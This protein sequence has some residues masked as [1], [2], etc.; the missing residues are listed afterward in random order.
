VE[1][2][3]FLGLIELV[4]EPGSKEEGPKTTSFI[5]MINVT[6]GKDY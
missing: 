3:L 6:V 1:P 2:G 5:L 4:I